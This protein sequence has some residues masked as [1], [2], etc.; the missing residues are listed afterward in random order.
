MYCNSSTIFP[1][2]QWYRQKPGEH[3]VFL[4][5]LVKVG[6][7]K[8][9]K[10]MAAWLGEARKSSSLNICMVQPED[11]GT[12]LCAGAQYSWGTCCL[13]P[14]PATAPSHT[15]AVYL[16]LLLVGLKIGT[17][18]WARG[19]STSAKTLRKKA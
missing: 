4:M 1:S 18:E 8:K 11:A 13:H 5:A 16:P 3:P 9:Q 10:R 2:F 14:N 17:E 7:V 12:Y 15:A 19:G 6:D